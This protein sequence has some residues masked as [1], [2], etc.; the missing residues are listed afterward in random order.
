MYLEHF[1]LRELPFSITPDTGFTYLAPSHTAAHHTVRLAL[2]QGEGFIKITGEVGTG[3]TLLARTLLDALAAEAQAAGD[4]A[5]HVTAYLP[6]PN[7]TGRELLRALASELQLKFTKR[8]A[9]RDL[10]EAVAAALLRHGEAGRTVILVI[11]EAQAMPAT[12]VECLRLMSNLETAKRKL[13]QVVFFGQPELDP[14]LADPRCRS[15]ASRIAFSA[16]LQPLKPTD[17]RRYLAHRLHVA[18]WRGPTVFSPAAAWVLRHASYGVPRRANILAHKS[19]LLAYGSG[20]HQVTW[21]HALGAALDGHTSWRE[22][23]AALGLLKG[24]LA[25]AEAQYTGLAA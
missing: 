16:R 7:M 18:G 14:L 4:A 15:L 25:G 20:V 10:Y 12:T 22:R 1:H 24:R 3:K 13:L 11:D 6:N 9:S 5:Q 8:E 21:Q 19:L 2:A 17:F 23:A